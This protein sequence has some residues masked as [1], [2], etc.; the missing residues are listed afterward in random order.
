MQVL[1]EM[2]LPLDAEESALKAVHIEPRWP[3]A[4]QTLGRTRINCGHI[5]MVSRVPLISDI[6]FGKMVCV[7]ILF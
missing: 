5:E 4:H 1:L 6:P 2:N 3:E 7:C